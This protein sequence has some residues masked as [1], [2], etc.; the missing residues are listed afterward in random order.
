MKKLF[1]LLLFIGCYQVS[2][3]QFSAG[4]GLSVITGDNAAFGLQAR[5]LYGINDDF[6]AGV[7]YNYYFE[8]E[9]GSIIDLD[10]QYNLLNTDGGFVINPL[11]GITIKT[12]DNVD[13][14]IHLGFYSVIPIGG[15]H[16]YLEP[17]FIISDDDAFVISTG[18][19]F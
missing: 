6:T 15:Y 3:A 10:L 18:F 11:A 17:K 5:L 2:I 12:V 16:F 14:D 9:I 19:R 7:S 1:T 8:K 4:A 13:T